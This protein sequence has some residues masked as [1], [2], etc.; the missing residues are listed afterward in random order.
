MKVFLES[1]T[2]AN[3]TLYPDL[4]SLTVDG[5][6]ISVSSTEFALARALFEEPG[7]VVSRERFYTVLRGNGGREPANLLN[8]FIHSVRRKLRNAGARAKL[9]TVRGRGYVVTAPQSAELATHRRSGPI[10]NVQKAHNRGQ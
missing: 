8:V 2:V 10:R 7:A 9:A 1:R 5:R 6:P 4:A 3:V